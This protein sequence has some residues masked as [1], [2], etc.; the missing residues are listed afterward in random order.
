MRMATLPRMDQPTRLVGLGWAAGAVALAAGLLLEVSAVHEHRLELLVLAWL[1]PL[2]VYD[3]HR[4]QVPHIVCVAVPCAAAVAYSIAT[5]TWMP[6]VIAALAILASERQVIRHPTLKKW[7]FS[8]TLLLGGLLALASGEAVPGA[9][10]VLGFWLAYETGWWAG[11]D[12]LAAITLA[13]LWPDIRLLV[14]LAI[15]H[16]FVALAMPLLR[17][18][19]AFFWCA[20]T[21]ANVP[22][23]RI[24][25]VSGNMVPGLPVIT[26]SVVLLIVWRIVEQAT[27]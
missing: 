7:V 26:L 22:T 12:A 20:Q 10:A 18:A 11:A 21:T 15:A 19:R 9:F 1:A 16:F 27:W 23:I 24:A 14:V 13:L 17:P 3:L 8:A 6:A 2:A 25:P 4:K 5:G